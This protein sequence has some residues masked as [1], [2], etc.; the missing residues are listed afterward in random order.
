MKG[1]PWGA[2]HWKFQIGEGMR[3]LSP[4]PAALVIQWHA[5]LR[6]LSTVDLWPRV[7][8]HLQEDAV[9]DRAQDLA[10]LDARRGAADDRQTNP[11]G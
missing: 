1:L 8:A 4:Y 6:L 5:Y 11:G 3:P 2:I 9:V 7:P 10:P